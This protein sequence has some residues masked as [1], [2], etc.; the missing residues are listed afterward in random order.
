M[1]SHFPRTTSAVWHT[2]RV[3]E[4][5]SLGNFSPDEKRL[6]RKIRETLAKAK[7][8]AEV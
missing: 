7:D 3:E 1:L 4:M 6:A 5:F 8:K 2:S